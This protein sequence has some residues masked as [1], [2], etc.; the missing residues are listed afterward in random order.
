MAL[1]FVT[2]LPSERRKKRR[3]NEAAEEKIEKKRKDIRLVSL[4]N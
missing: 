3:E 2:A 4:N 1:C